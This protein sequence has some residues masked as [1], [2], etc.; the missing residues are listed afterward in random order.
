MDHTIDIGT[1]KVVARL[2][3]V[4]ERSPQEAMNRTIL[5]VPAFC[6]MLN[7]KVIR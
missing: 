4:I 6:G 1:K 7:D 2:K 5:P 3:H